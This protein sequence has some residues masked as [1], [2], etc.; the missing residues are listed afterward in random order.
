MYTVMSWNFLV[1]KGYNKIILDQ[2]LLVKKGYMVYLEQNIDKGRVAVDQSGNAFYSD[3]A[4]KP[5]LERLNGFSLD[6][7][8]LRQITNFT[9][10]QATINLYHTYSQAGLYPISIT[11]ISSNQ[12]FENII[13]ITD[14]KFICLVNQIR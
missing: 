1:I 9:S 2:P 8:Y 14:C 12:T 13:N 11:T 4:W 3:I 5:Y 10:Y 7:F 6:R